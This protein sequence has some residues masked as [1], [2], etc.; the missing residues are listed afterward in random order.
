MEA[1]TEG[2]LSGG[3]ATDA[4]AGWLKGGIVEAATG[5]AE[6][7]ALA[8]WLSAGWLTAWPLSNWEIR[9]CSS[10]NISRHLFKSDMILK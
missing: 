2:W 3:G 9:L 5:P 6:T 8:G 1:A 7:A 4:A 10:V